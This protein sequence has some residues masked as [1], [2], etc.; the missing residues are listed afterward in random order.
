MELNPR[1]QELVRFLEPHAAAGDPP[2]ASSTVIDAYKSR[3]KLDLQQQRGRS[4]KGWLL[5]GPE[6]TN[7]LS[8]TPALRLFLVIVAAL[9]ACAAAV[10]GGVIRSVEATA[11]FAFVEVVACAACTVVVRWAPDFLRRRRQQWRR[12]PVSVDGVD[13][14]GLRLNRAGEGSLSTRNEQKENLKKAEEEKSSRNDVLGGGAVAAPT[15]AADSG[16]VRVVMGAEIFATV[17]VLIVYVVNVAT[18]RGSVKRG[19]GAGDFC[20]PARGGANLLAVVLR[21]AIGVAWN[22]AKEAVVAVILAVVL[23]PVIAAIATRRSILRPTNGNGGDVT[24]ATTLLEEAVLTTVAIGGGAASLLCCVL[25]ASLPVLA[26]FLAKLHDFIISPLS[27]HLPGAAPRSKESPSS[28]TMTRHVD[29]VRGPRAI[30]SSRGETSEK[31]GKAV[32]PVSSTWK[33]KEAS[34][35]RGRARGK[36]DDPSDSRGAT[37]WRRVR[38]RVDRVRVS[39][40]RAVMPRSE[41]EGGLHPSSSSSKKKL[42]SP[43]RDGDKD[44]TAYPSEEPELPSLASHEPSWSHTAA[45]GV[46]CLPSSTEESVDP[47]EVERSETNPAWRFQGPL[48]RKGLEWA[49]HSLGAVDRAAA[50]MYA[51]RRQCARGG[52]VRTCGND[53]LVEIADVSTRVT[54]GGLEASTAMFGS[55]ADVVLVWVL[56]GLLWAVLGR[57]C[58][59]ARRKRWR[60]LALALAGKL[61][62]VG[63]CMCV[64]EMSI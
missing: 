19:A 54:R 38:T 12:Q 2:V 22:G 3:G 30:K 15:A 60:R 27:R 26:Y 10:A 41:G 48:G 56:V 42:Q 13:G 29:A 64:W 57:E 40:A 44:E 52:G 11:I 24:P 4:L 5:E 51:P 1:P 31:E 39:I 50:A 62:L 21:S 23:P 37:V 58:R 25:A 61:V 9:E 18:P 8:T 20:A 28:P 59:L 53:V 35:E 14:S 45:S 43:R 47:W 32:S 36:R 16:W 33:A 7:P 6:A 55:L 34:R 17:M 46:R 49:S 63:V